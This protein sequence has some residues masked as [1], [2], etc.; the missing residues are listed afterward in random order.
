MYSGMEFADDELKSWVPQITEL[1]MLKPDEKIW[2]RVQVSKI[3]RL[4]RMRG[5]LKEKGISDPKKECKFREYLS[6]K[7]FEFEF[8]EK[9]TEDLL[10]QE[11]RERKNSL[12]I[13]KVT[14]NWSLSEKER[15]RKI[16]RMLR[17]YRRRR[18]PSDKPKERFVKVVFENNLRELERIMKYLEERKQKTDEKERERLKLAF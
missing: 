3:W 2:V 17:L 13:S 6:D 4:N 7:F 16:R 8:N 1:L 5:F 12:V 14:M 10:K 9:K 11:A 18:K 15:R